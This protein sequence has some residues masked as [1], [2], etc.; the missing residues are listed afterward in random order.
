[1]LSV[2]THPHL[3]I[4]A[5]GCDNSIIK[6]FNVIVGK[7]T[8]TLPRVGAVRCVEFSTDGRFLFSAHESPENAAV[9]R[10]TLFTVNMWNCHDNFRFI[11]TSPSYGYHTGA[12]TSICPCPSRLFTDSI[13]PSERIKNVSILASGGED[14]SVRL[15]N[16]ETEQVWDV[17]VADNSNEVITSVSF[18]SDG[19]MLAASTL[20]RNP[21]NKEK[22]IDSRLFVWRVNHIS[23]D[24]A[25]FGYVNQVAM[26]PNLQPVYAMKFFPEKSANVEV[27][28][29]VERKVQEQFAHEEEALPEEDEDLKM[30]RMKT[31][32]ARA[33]SMENIMD[34]QLDPTAPTVVS[35]DDWESAMAPKNSGYRTSTVGAFGNGSK[36]DSEFRIC[37]GGEKSLSVYNVKQKNKEDSRQH[38]IVVGDQYV[39]LDKG[40]TRQSTVGGRSRGRTIDSN[41]TGKEQRNYGL[42]N[43]FDDDDDED[44]NA[45]NEVECAQL[46]FSEHSGRITTLDISED[47][48]YIVTGDIGPSSTANM[49]TY[50][51][52]LWVLIGE[53]ITSSFVGRHDL[54]IMDV[55]F[56]KSNANSLLQEHGTINR[57]EGFFASAS[58]DESVRMWMWNTY[59]GR[60]ISGSS[61]V[62]ER[63]LTRQQ[64]NMF[65]S[66]NQR[67]ERAREDLTSLKSKVTAAAAAQGMRNAKEEDDP[68]ADY[69]DE[70]IDEEE[71][72]LNALANNAMNLE[73]PAAVISSSTGHVEYPNRRDK[74]KQ[75]KMLFTFEKFAQN[76]ESRDMKMK[77]ENQGRKCRTCSLW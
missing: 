30:L 4:I 8:H 66:M 9:D 53:T 44:S 21:Y 34:V 25:E 69:D 37:C 7:C 3:P 14:G 46:Y 51:V 26:Q 55:S 54:Q 32:R 61:S 29:A 24:Q 67:L 68:M 22:G 48:Y 52:N 11:K 72:Q 33:R 20:T 15:W 50:N 31:M 64:I 75:S 40:P 43:D 41:M 23:V 28:D 17:F 19:S 49:S 45:R 1:M 27:E 58:L 59:S 42:N 56:T 57:D 12:I 5:I 65:R 77:R 47:G 74:V 10:N 71:E 63:P 2:A 39:Y 16:Y 18:S 38:Y 76:T 70:P 35:V 62:I 73:Q 6:I 60:Y 36:S 13:I